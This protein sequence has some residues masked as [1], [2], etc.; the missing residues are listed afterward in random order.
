MNAG[1]AHDFSRG[2]RSYLIFE[3]NRTR[4]DS[5]EAR[6]RARLSVATVVAAIITEQNGFDPRRAAKDLLQP[7]DKT[8]TH[9]K[10]LGYEG[11]AASLER[12]KALVKNQADYNTTLNALLRIDPAV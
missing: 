4:L 12:V 2:R 9:I 8:I 6:E 11:D 3:Q 10:A 7:P 1:E 5:Y